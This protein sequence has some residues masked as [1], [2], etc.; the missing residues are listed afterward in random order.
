MDHLPWG[1]TDRPRPTVPNFC[2]HLRE[3][4]LCPDYESFIDWPGIQE[5]NFESDTKLSSLAIYCQSWLFL[6]LA[7]VVAGKYGLSTPIFDLI[8]TDDPSVLDTRKITKTFLHLR[9]NDEQR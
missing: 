6:G 9:W 7:K 5:W 3:A 4:D 1:Y 8:P 2:G